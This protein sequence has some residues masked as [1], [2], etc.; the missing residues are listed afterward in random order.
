MK[1]LHRLVVTSTAY[2]LASTPDER[3]ASVDPD[4]VYLWRMSSRRLEA[5][6]VRDSVLYV[7]GRLDETQGGAEIDHQRILET[8][9]NSVEASPPAE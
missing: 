4:N 9:R 5:E 3:N 1:H 8:R 2:R 6:A 7:S